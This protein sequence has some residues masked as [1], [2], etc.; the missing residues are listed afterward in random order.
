MLRMLSSQAWVELIIQE[1]VKYRNVQAS[2]YQRCPLPSYGK[3]DALVETPLQPT[4]PIGDE[5]LWILFH[6][7]F[8]SG[9][10]SLSLVG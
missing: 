9:S 1:F 7:V 2:K 4:A 10:L 6:D 8:G 3:H 5:T